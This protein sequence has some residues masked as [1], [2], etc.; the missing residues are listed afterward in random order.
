MQ[1]QMLA[2]VTRSAIGLAA[3][4]VVAILALQNPASA[5]QTVNLTV[6]SGYPPV[7]A[8][9]KVFKDYYVPEVAKRLAKT[10]NY[11]INWNEGF[12]GTIAKPAGELDAVEKGLADLGM[13]QTVFHPDKV[14]LYGVAYATPFVTTDIGLVVRTVNQLTQQFPAMKDG[15]G[16]YNQVFLTTLGTVD[17]YQIASRKPIK[18]LSDFKGLKIGGAGP[19]LRYLEGIGATGVASNLVEMYNN[20]KTGVADGWVIWAEAAANF[21]VNEVAPYYVVA[22]L[23]A[24]NS[25][26]LSANR[27]A[28]AKLPPEVKTVLAEVALGYAD[29]LAKYVNKTS[30]AS[31]QRFVANG[32]KLVK[33]TPDQRKAW[34]KVLPNIGKQWAQSLEKDGLPG[35][36]VLS[37]YMD[38]MRKNK[39]PILRDWDKE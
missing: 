16:R 37:A 10:G 20:L 17:N 32:G 2:R 5:A 22:D 15:W 35:L 19:N 27:T 6:V 23:G 1:P 28:W 9:V 30:E 8:W 12:S 13:I 38:I 39:Q 33:L 24:A 31:V 25:I 7:A 18:S 29:E 3:S 34:A 14:P 21:K 36:A 4:A 26:A 11:R